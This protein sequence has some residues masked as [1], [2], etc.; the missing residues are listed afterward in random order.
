MFFK[1]IVAKEFIKFTG[2][3][4]VGVFFTKVAGPQNSNFV[5]KGLQPTINRKISGTNSSFHV[6]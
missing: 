2:N 6:E 4:C 3:I 1:K 5:K